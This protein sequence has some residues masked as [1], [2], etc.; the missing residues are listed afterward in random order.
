MKTPR[1]QT[2]LMALTMALTWSVVPAAA[3]DFPDVED[4]WAESYI[5]AMT[6]A[7]MFQGYEDGTFRPENQ[8]TTS[9][10]L[11]LC[12]RAVPLEES[13]EDQIEEVWTEQVTEILDGAH[14]WF[15][16]E[17]CI[18]LETGIL[19]VD[20]LQGIVD[21]D[22]MG[23]AVSKEDLSLYLV[24]AMQL[25]DT[26]LS[27]TSYTLPFGDNEDISPDIAPYIYLLN[28]YGIVQGDENGDFGPQ[29]SVT[30]AVMATMLSRA[31][32]F[33][34]DRGVVVEL[35]AYA[36]QLQQGVVESAAL[37]DDGQ[38]Y[39]EVASVLT[40]EVEAFW[41]PE[42]V[43]LYS[44]NM[45]TTV[46][47]LKVGNYL[48]I[49]MDENG[50]VE[51]IHIQSSLQGELVLFEDMVDDCIQVELDGET[52]LYPLTSFTEVQIED[53]DVGDV[54]LVDLEANY[55]TAVCYLEED[56]NLVAIRL[57]GGSHLET[58]LLSAIDDTS[59]DYT[60]IQIKALNGVIEQYQLDEDCVITINGEV[61][62]LNDI[63][64]GRMVTLS[65]AD[66][67]GLLVKIDI[68][69][70]TTYIQGSVYSTSTGN[71]AGSVTLTDLETGDITTYTSSSTCAYTYEGE[72]I[73]ISS[74]EE[75]W[76][77]SALV[78]SKTLLALYCYPGSVETE[79]TLMSY[80]FSSASTTVSMEILQSSG[81]TS[82][83]DFDLT[84]LP[85]I[86]RN[87]EESTVDKLKVGDTVTVT[88]RYQQVVEIDA[89]SQGISKEGTIQRIIQ[90]VSGYTVDVLLTD[91]TEVTYT[92]GSTVSV[93]QDGDNKSLSDLSPSQ[94]VILTV[95]GDE[96]T[97]IDIQKDATAS[98][99][100]TGTVV[101]VSDDSSNPYIYLRWTDSSTGL[102]SVITVMTDSSTTIL[103]WDGTSLD[104]DDLEVD[105][106]LQINGT[107]DSTTYT[108]KL[109]L[110]Q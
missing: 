70:E 21:A 89:T 96:V 91:G 45:S 94:K 74:V 106:S 77:V 29:G 84:T 62:S 32:D 85:D 17:F 72:S 23:S 44:G 30:R 63:Y 14:Y 46:N 36:T 5:E 50:D 54:S 82:Y 13:V 65:I 71:S 8:L 58:G 61:G 37:S 11:A 6:E 24:R 51:A 86:V 31:L 40:G 39:L 48:R 9:E 38:I 42:D 67:D 79:G 64:Q 4:H 2:G 7:G 83:F 80:S 103:E 55:V 104:L 41:L 75:D 99:Q 18:C 93:T 35:P 95:E 107:Y 25:E 22:I 59:Y 92:V 73:T 15:Y 110:R 109:I 60:T 53:G 43:P 10:V 98:E 57:L 81:I 49:Y 100:R 69:T 52:Y 47:S 27:L 68:D 12:A 87:D 108:A 20:D 78:D 102:T 28:I 90:E 97:E 26:A 88:V 34:E 19:S 66:A 101:Y 16:P 76:F 3:S 56:G 105:D 1:W 33:M